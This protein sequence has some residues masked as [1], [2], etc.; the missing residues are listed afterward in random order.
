MTCENNEFGGSVVNISTNAGYVTCFPLVPSSNMTIGSVGFKF[1]EDNSALTI[2]GG[3]YDSDPAE[4]H[5][6]DLLAQTNPTN[7][8]SVVD[9]YQNFNLTSSASVTASETVWVAIFCQDN[10]V[11]MYSQRN[12]GY[13]DY[14]QM[15]HTGTTLPSTFT[16]SYEA[17]YRGESQ[18]CTGGPSPTTSGTRLPPPPLVAYF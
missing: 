11:P 2:I 10:D 5:P 17:V 14:Q 13:D 15:A 3:L 12:T 1:R 6:A 4:E 8:T 16:S 7:P 18:I 9:E